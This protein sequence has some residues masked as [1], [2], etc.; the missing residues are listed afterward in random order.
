M[1]LWVQFRKRRDT[2]DVK[3]FEYAFW[4]VSQVLKK[5]PTWRMHKELN[6]FLFTLQYNLQNSGLLIFHVMRYINSIDTHHLNTSSQ[7]RC[8]N[9]C[10]PHHTRREEEELHILYWCF[11]VTYKVTH[12]TLFKS[13]PLSPYYHMPF[14]ILCFPQTFPFFWEYC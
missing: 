7:W 1:R 3:S 11:I 5:S 6:T 2:Y 8:T 14:K 13:I 12:T 9:H 10:F 4:I